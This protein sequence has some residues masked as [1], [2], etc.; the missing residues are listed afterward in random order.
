MGL[1]VRGRRLQRSRY[2]PDH[3]GG[4]EWLVVGSGLVA[5]GTMTLAHTLKVPGMTV[6]FVPLTVPPLPLLPVVGI[7]IAALPAVVVPARR[8]APTPVRRELEPAVT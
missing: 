3:W 5:L 1:V 7:L 2:R 6:S 8:S 4:Q